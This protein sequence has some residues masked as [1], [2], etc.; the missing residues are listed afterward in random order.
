MKHQIQT[1]ELYVK[2]SEIGMIPL[3]GLICVCKFWKVNE[4]TQ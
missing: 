4:S 1:I 3:L 2:T